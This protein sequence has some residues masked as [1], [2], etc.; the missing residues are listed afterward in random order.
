MDNVSA[1]QK[2]WLTTLLLCLFL[3]GLGVHRFYTGHTVIGI[4][5]LL[6]LGGCGIWS[7]V[8]LI[9]IA[10]GSY[11]DASGNALLKK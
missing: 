7:L 10:I 1:P 2:D 4:V 3:G 8:D 5:Q 6:T 11:K 9:M